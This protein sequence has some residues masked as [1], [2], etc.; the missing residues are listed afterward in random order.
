MGRLAVR[1][2]SPPN[3]SS[4]LDFG[5]GRLAGQPVVAGCLASTSAAARTSLFAVRGGLSVE[6]DGDSFAGRAFF[7]GL[8]GGDSGLEQATL[9]IWGGPAGRF[10]VAL[11]GVGRRPCWAGIYQFFG[12][13]W[14]VAAARYGRGH[15]AALFAADRRSAAFVGGLLICVDSPGGV[16]LGS[17]VCR[18]LGL[19][20]RV[21]RAAL[22]G[23]IALSRLC[24][25]VLWR[26]PAAGGQF[27]FPRAQ[28]HG[29]ALFALGHDPSGP[30]LGLGWAVLAAEKSGTATT[31]LG[32]RAVRGRAGW[33]A[34][35]CPQPRL[36]QR[37]SLVCCGL[38]ALS[39]QRP[40][41]RQSRVCLLS[42]GTIHPRF[43]PLPAGRG[44]PAD[45]V[46][47]AF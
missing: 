30:D 31:N 36:A 45:P 27:A 9:G 42:A 11:A 39:R 13:P 1:E 3:R 47:S 16:A 7:S 44:H 34:H 18:G 19:C 25:R 24:Q 23:A 46:A 33:C 15:S 29:R 20:G 5:A 21:G 2:P 35:H 32:S 8:T 6:G 4:S 37:R 43:P 17:V 26:V 28:R 12:R 38:G 41:P 14:S 10:G 40:R 22:G